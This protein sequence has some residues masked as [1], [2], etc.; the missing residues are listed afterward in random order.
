MTMA[1]VQKLRAPLAASNSLSCNTHAGCAGSLEVSS[2]LLIAVSQ[3]DVVEG[4]CRWR[5]TSGSIQRPPP[6]PGQDRRRADKRPCHGAF[7]P[8]HSPTTDGHSTY[9]D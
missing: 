5:A 3:N 2:I 1:P 4:L 9:A 6:Q 7:T 8:A